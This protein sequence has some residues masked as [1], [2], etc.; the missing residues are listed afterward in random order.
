M[1]PSFFALVVGDDDG[2]DLVAGVFVAGAEP[3]LVSFLRIVGVGAACRIA[4]HVIRVRIQFG[5]VRRVRL[6]FAAC[7]W[8]A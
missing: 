2:A 8:C 5:C 7:M 4:G 3:V 1:E 6:G